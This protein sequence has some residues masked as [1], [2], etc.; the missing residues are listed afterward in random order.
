MGVNRSSALWSPSL[1]ARSNWLMS[2]AAALADCA[3]LS[4][5]RLI[6]PLRSMIVLRRSLRLPRRRQEN[7]MKLILTSIAAGSLL[8]TLVMA[9]PSPR[10]TLTDL[11]PKGTPSSFGGFVNSYGLVAGA[12]AGP[13]G[14][15]HAAVWNNGLLF[16]ISQPGLAG[17]NS[18]ACCVNEIGQVLMQGE[19]T[20]DPNNENFC[21]YGDGLICATYLWQFGAI[22]QLPT[23]GGNNT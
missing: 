15:Q 20:K 14:A 18:L 5:G 13:G 16:D 3:V 7:T 4:I 1:H 2:P 11:N 23:L 9:Q 19:T 22:K 12:Y 6:I 17:P 8:A 21:G 10:Y